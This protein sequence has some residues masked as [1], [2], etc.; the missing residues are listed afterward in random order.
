MYTHENIVKKVDFVFLSNKRA[1]IRWG[2]GGWSELR[3]QGG[4]PYEF[5]FKRN[6]FVK[7]SFT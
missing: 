4:A 6:F 7:K 5:K 3:G 2:K 1:E